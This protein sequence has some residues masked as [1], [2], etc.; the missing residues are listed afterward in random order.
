MD[1]DRAQPLASGGLSLSDGRGLQ[2]SS[3]S[4]HAGFAAEYSL[5]EPLAGVTTPV[6][7]QLYCELRS[8][9]GGPG[10]GH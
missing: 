1:T 6:T 3:D 7:A 10:E 2:G 5:L 4:D 9:G 8:S